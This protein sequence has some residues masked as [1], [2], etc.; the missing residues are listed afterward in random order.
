[1]FCYSIQL[2]NKEDAEYRHQEKEAWITTDIRSFSAA[3]ISNW[4]L[5]GLD[6]DKLGVSADFLAD[7]KSPIVPADNL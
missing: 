4:H 7:L 6:I 5:L 1:L 3:G 2:L